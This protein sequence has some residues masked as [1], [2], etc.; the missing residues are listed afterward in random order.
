LIFPSEQ[1]R[2]EDFQKYI[3][4]AQS[5]FEEFTGSNKG[6]KGAERAAANTTATTTAS[7]VVN[8]GGLA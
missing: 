2:E 1:N 6:D 3:D 7:I 4:V 5:I 8:K